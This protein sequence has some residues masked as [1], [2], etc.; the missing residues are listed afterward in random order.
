MTDLCLILTDYESL[1]SDFEVFL[2]L[3]I[4]EEIVLSEDLNIKNSGILALEHLAR[5]GSGKIEQVL[6]NKIFETVF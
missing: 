4:L 5:S 1:L 3:E 2:L 6:S